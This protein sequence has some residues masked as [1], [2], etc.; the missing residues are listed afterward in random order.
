MLHSS[1]RA[2]AGIRA[3]TPSTDQSALAGGAEKL[4]QA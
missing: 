1:A 3:L 4:H 2:R